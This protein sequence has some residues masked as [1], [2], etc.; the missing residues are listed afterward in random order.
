MAGCM[1][2]A[3]GLHWECAPFDLAASCCGV[4]VLG[5]HGEVFSAKGGNI[6]QVPVE[7]Q[8]ARLL[9]SLREP[10]PRVAH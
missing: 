3:R 2:D 7:P 4:G 8:G 9:I 6:A 1:W 10:C 5:Y